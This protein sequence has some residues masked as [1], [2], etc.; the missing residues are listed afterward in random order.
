MNMEKQ[1]IQQLIDRYM[2]AETTQAEEAL[3]A[4]YFCTHHD[5]PAEWRTFSI[6]FRGLRQGKAQEAPRRKPTL[7]RWS[8]AAVVVVAMGAGLLFLPSDHSD[9]APTQPVAVAVHQARQTVAPQS[10]APQPERQGLPF[11]SVEFENRID[12]LMAALQERKDTALCD[13]T[14]YSNDREG[15]VWWDGINGRCPTHATVVRTRYSKKDHAALRQQLLDACQGNA[16]PITT[17]DEECQFLLL[18]WRDMALR[19]HG[20]L[21]Y[22]YPDGQLVVVRADG[23][24]AYQICI[25]HY[26]ADW[27][28]AKR[29]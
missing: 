16:H 1:H 18:S 27:F 26:S 2:A 28:K 12:S 9:V 14:F 8:A 6:L 11:A 21:V 10:V 22:Y 19:L 20:L 15:H 5:V 3:L 4:D 13:T 24:N 17:D 25:P 7:L 23:L 29:K